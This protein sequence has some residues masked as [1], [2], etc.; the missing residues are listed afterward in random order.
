MTVTKKPVKRRWAAILS[1]GGVYQ[2]L[3]AFLVLKK[4]SGLW[5]KQVCPRTR[6]AVRQ[7]NDAGKLE[8]GGSTVPETLNEDVYISLK[9][10]GQALL[11]GWALKSAI[12]TR[13]NLTDAQ[14]NYLTEVFQGRERTGKKADPSIISKAM[15]R[16][17]LS[18]GS[19]IFE[20]DD[21]LTP[22]QIAGLFLA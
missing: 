18:N 11:M 17:K 16:A 12:A 3:P 19:S 6:N 10:K 9:N 5:Q 21:F 15:Q 4:T 1:R 7:S 22:Q 14:K 13:K 20:K 8:H 2:N